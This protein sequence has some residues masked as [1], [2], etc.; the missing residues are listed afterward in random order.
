MCE[1]FL[2]LGLIAGTVALHESSRTAIALSSSPFATSPTPVPSSASATTGWSS[3]ASLLRYRSNTSSCAAKDRV[4]VAEQESRGPSV[5]DRVRDEPLEQGQP[6]GSIGSYQFV[7]SDDRR[8]LVVQIMMSY[9]S[10]AQRPSHLELWHER[11]VRVPRSECSVGHF[12]NPFVRTRLEG[13]G[14]LSEEAT[15]SA[16]VARRNP[17]WRFLS[18]RPL[19][20]GQD[21]AESG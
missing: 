17:G 12:N 11:P 1:C 16:P 21:A 2:D 18:A 3:G 19:S 8:F 10:R 4:L 7:V 14:D 9:R 13:F 15:C 6:R 20:P 5:E